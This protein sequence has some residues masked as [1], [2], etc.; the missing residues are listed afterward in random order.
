MKELS[1]FR[2][3]ERVVNV[4]VSPICYDGSTTINKRLQNRLFKSL[5]IR[6]IGYTIIGQYNNELKQLAIKY[7][8]CN[9]NDKFIKRVGY[10]EALKNN[11]CLIISIE[12]NSSIAGIRKQFIHA[13]KSL[14]K[15]LEK[16]TKLRV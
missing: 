6:P 10:E 1:D 8:I 11:T 14:I 7:S 5:Q 2:L 13:A 3:Y 15:V 9:K 12:D 16:K 4:Q